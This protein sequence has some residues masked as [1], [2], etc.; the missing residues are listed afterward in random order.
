MLKDVPELLTAKEL[1]GGIRGPERGRTTDEHPSRGRP[2]GE[3]DDIEESALA[4]PRRT[5]KRDKFTRFNA[6]GYPS[7]DRSLGLTGAEH[8]DY[9]VGLKWK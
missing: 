4:T 5:H 3:P 2:I 1:Q 8:L 6:K 9:V 7:K